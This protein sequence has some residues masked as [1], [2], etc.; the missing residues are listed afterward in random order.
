MTF[1]VRYIPHGTALPIALAIAGASWLLIRQAA[2]S[3]IGRAEA[4][5]AWAGLCLMTAA[6]VGAAAERP[7]VPSCSSSGS[8]CS[9]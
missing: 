2:H 3:G 8:R 7:N 6:G 9:R 5:L 4:D 1:V